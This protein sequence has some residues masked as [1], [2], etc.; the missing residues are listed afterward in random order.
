MFVERP[1]LWIFPLRFGFTVKPIANEYVF[2]SYGKTDVKWS[3]AEI[4]AFEGRHL[5]L[6]ASGQAIVTAVVTLDSCTTKT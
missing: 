5:L 4:C 3:A 1:P 2:I 6:P